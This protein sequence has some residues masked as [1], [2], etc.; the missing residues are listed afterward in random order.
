VANTSAELGVVGLCVAL[1]L[2]RFVTSRSD[3]LMSIPGIHFCRY[4]YFPAARK[5]RENQAG[6]QSAEPG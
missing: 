3:R 2:T 4:S 6:S 5:W 1:F